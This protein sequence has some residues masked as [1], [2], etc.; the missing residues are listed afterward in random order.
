M[1]DVIPDAVLVQIY[2]LTLQ[3]N[4]WGKNKKSYKSTADGAILMHFRGLLYS[5]GSQQSVSGHAPI[6]IIWRILQWEMLLFWLPPPPSSYKMIALLY[7]PGDNSQVRELTT[8]I[9]VQC[10]VLEREQNKEQ[11]V[12][13]LE[14][15]INCQKK[16]KQLQ[17]I[18]QN[19]LFFCQTT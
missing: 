10:R 18:G 3:I 8:Y 14:N 11:L 5:P 16:E 1:P 2:W 6:F 9:R 13:I 7:N 19:S 12:V 15:F 17:T 4:S